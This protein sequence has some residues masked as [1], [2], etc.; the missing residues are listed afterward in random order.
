MDNI[1]YIV[2]CCSSVGFLRFPILM[3]I[4]NIILTF[5]AI[6]VA[7]SYKRY[8]KIIYFCA[9]QMFHIV[10]LVFDCI[11]KNTKEESS[12]YIIMGCDD[13]SRMIILFMMVYQ[14]FRVVILVV[15]SCIYRYKIRK[16]KK[17]F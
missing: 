3:C 9:F 11:N 5:I 2:I 6:W 15:Q 13:L 16:G 7:F 17:I 12:I 1:Y 8:G 14:L 4:S 10:I